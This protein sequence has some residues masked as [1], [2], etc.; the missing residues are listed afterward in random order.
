M[1]RI[2]TAFISILVVGMMFSM[3]ILSYASATITLPANKVWTSSLSASRSGAY[4]NAKAKLL[5]VYPTSGSDNYTKAQVRLVNGSGNQISEKSYVVLTEGSGWK[6]VKIADGYL[7]LKT[8]YF[9]FR[10]NSNDSAMAEVD[11]AGGTR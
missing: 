7:N 11:Y 4:E 10:G 8:I 6:K 1:K 9:Q 5:A 3:S 2:K